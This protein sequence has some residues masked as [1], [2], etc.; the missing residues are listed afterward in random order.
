M[1]TAVLGI[2]GGIAAFKAAELASLLGKRGWDTHTVLTRNATRFIAPLTFAGLT[3]HVAHVDAFAPGESILHIDLARKADVVAI[4]PASANFLAKMA[5]GLADDLLS[6]I[7]LAT[8]A[9]VV[10]APAMNVEM[11]R[12]PATQDNLARLRGRGIVVVQPD[13]GELACGEVGQG[14]LAS[15]ET[16]Y[17]HLETACGRARQLSGRT[18]MVTAGG[19]REPIDPV[20][21]IG[22]RSSGKMGH[23]LALEAARRGA[24]V[25]LVTT[26]AAPSHPGIQ[27]V[28]VETAAQLAA[29][30]LDRLE[31][32]DALIMAAAVADWR[33]AR[34]S[35]SKLKKSNGAPPVILDPT[36]DVL[37]EAGRRRRRELLLVGFAAETDDLLAHARAKLETKNVD[38]LVANDATSA[39]DADDNAVVI[40]DRNGVVADLPR[41]PKTALAAG[42]WDILASRLARVPEGQ[43]HDRL[44][45]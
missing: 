20:R 30:V 1:R 5:G 21:Y 22:N 25:V 37:A 39:M 17:A 11:W 36:L 45:A 8:T 34:P 7:V 29:A 35:P 16:I 15:I 26:T 43:A 19:T 18:V 10:V 24:Q 33:P 3:H 40:L 31:S 28:Q 32:L 6:T 23:A 44:D 27:V 38:L 42:L 4:V 13:D 41:Q 12:N 9:P 2:T 14:R